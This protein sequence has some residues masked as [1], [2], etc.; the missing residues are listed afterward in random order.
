MGYKLYMNIIATL[1]I[2]ILWTNKT[3]LILFCIINSDELPFFKDW[4]WVQIILYNS[5]QWWQCA[6]YTQLVFPHNTGC[7]HNTGAPMFLIKMYTRLPTWADT[8]GLS[9]WDNW[10][11]LNWLW[12]DLNH[13]IVNWLLVQDGRLMGLNVCS[14]K[15]IYYWIIC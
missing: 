9:K 5:L 4:F 14:W 11:I 2:I 7:C 15:Y 13:F 6:M 12:G 8:K 1:T 3:K 10:I